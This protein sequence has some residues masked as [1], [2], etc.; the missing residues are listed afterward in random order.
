MNFGKAFKELR[1][2]KGLSR[3]EVAKQIGCTQSSLSKIE[4]NKVQ[5]KPATID[6][7]C[8][9]CVTPVARFYNLAFEADDFE[10]R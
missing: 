1:E 9:I 5:P 8:V 7:F 2:E 4:R 6:A 3:K 10:M